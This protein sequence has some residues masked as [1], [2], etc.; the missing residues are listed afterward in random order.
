MA[1]PAAT[2]LPAP[3][4]IATHCARRCQ[5]RPPLGVRGP[6]SDANTVHRPPYRKHGV[7]HALVAT[8][9]Q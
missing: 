8:S 1:R 4:S 9:Q 6:N 3:S 5:A 7:M 2:G